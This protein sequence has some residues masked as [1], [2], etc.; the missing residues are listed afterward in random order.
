MSGTNRTSALA[1]H[2]DSVSQRITAGEPFGAVEDA[3]DELA[4]LTL[5]QKAALWLL[6]FSLR[7][8]SQQQVDA[9]AHLTAV[10]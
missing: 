8:Q 3:I 1:S 5:D 6:A 10:Q 4:D 2:V 7:D 9:R